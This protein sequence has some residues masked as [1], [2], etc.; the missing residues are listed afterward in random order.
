MDG[1]R[2]DLVVPNSQSSAGESSDD[3]QLLAPH[4]S[5]RRLFPGS[6][7]K[8][9]RPCTVASIST[10]IACVLLMLVVLC[11]SGPRAAET[12]PSPQF[13]PSNARTPCGNVP[14]ANSSMY[15]AVRARAAATIRSI[16]PSLPN[17]TWALLV[18]G[19]DSSLGYSDTEVPF[20][21]E[22]NFLYLTGWNMSGAIALFSVDDGS[23][24]LLLQVCR[25]L[26]LHYNCVS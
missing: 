24:Y 17:N 23:L 22:S 11:Y 5:S 4:Q 16:S 12:W 7:L 26:L 14:P 20:R 15:L 8:W 19:R 13:S 2:V 21:Q 9:N 1:V 18:G 10:T 25:H 3:V 6:P